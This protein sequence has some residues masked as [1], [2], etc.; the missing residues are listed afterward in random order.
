MLTREN[1][2]CYTR[3]Q[4]E[5]ELT[6]RLNDERLAETRTPRKLFKSIPRMQRE[7]SCKRLGTKGDLS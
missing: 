7:L 6:S 4:F 1:L 5:M 2:W 3:V